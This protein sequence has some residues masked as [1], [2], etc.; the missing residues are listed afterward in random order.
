MGVSAEMYRYGT[1]L[2]LQIFSF[3]ALVPAV[4][5]FYAPIFHRLKVASSFEVM[6]F[7][8]HKYC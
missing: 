5:Y 7:T 1:M 8:F 4:I 3:L 2:F 6:M